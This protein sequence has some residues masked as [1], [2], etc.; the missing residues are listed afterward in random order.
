ME[1]IIQSSVGFI[2]ETYSLT[3]LGY[4]FRNFSARILFT[5]G[6]AESPLLELAIKKRSCRPGEVFLTWVGRD[7][8]L[9]RKSAAD[10]K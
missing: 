6:C 5:V 4:E 10:R 7:H 9:L 2:G 3:N 8:G 1:T